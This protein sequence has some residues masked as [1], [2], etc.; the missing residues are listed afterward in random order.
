MKIVC[1]GESLE[2]H[3]AIVCQ[4][5]LFF[6]AAFWGNFEEGQTKTI[7]LD[8]EKLSMVRRMMRYC[9]LFD[10]NDHDETAMSDVEVNARMYAIADRFGVPG[11]KKAAAAKFARCCILSQ[12]PFGM[13]ILLKCVETVYTSTPDTDNT[14]RESL[15]TAIGHLLRKQQ[16]LVET[17]QFKDTC[18]QFADFA[19]Q[20]IKTGI[21]SGS[22]LRYPDR[23]NTSNDD[24]GADVE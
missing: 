18:L 24:W 23:W 21:S 11:L 12:T 8:M 13:E 10:Y 15:A 9:Y 17:S 16:N 4:R 6:E 20:M 5:A 19:Y 3:S 2:Y 1:G 7:I 14:L 22:T